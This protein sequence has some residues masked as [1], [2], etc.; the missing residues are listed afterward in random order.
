MKESC[1][2]LTEPLD[3]AVVAVAHSAELAMPKRT[4]LPSMLPPGCVALCVWSTPKAGKPRVAALLRPDSH[5]DQH[6]KDDRHRRQDGP[7]LARVAHHLAEGVAERSRNQQD[8]QHLQEVGQRRRD[9]RTDA[10]S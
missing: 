8:R 7:A 3:A 9:S 5:R 10:P 6:D 2:A 4:S 1:I